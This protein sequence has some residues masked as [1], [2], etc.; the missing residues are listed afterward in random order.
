MKEL[1]E[2]KFNNFCH[3]YLDGLYEPRLPDSAQ[4][5]GYTQLK[6][7]VVEG[8]TPASLEEIVRWETNPTKE[9]IMS[10]PDVKYLRF[11]H[12]LLRPIIIEHWGVIKNMK[13][14]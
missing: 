13:V 1:K 8:I 14:E 12:P 10:I 7:M 11:L 3:L 9:E 2:M 6:R 5:T 4:C